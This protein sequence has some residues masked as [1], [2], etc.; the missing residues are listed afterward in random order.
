MLKFWSKT[1]TC[2]I[3]AASALMPLGSSVSS[4]A[5][6]VTA[7]AATTSDF[8]DL[9]QAELTSAMGVGWNVG[10]TCEALNGS[11][12]TETA[13]G[14]PKVTQ[15]LIDEVK[16]EGFKSIRLPVGWLTNIGAA[17]DYTLSSTWLARIKEI[18]DYCVKDDL[19]VIV[20]MHSDGYHSI[21]GAWLFCDAPASEQTAIVDK[22][23]KSW[24]QF[25]DY[26]KDYDEHLIF[27]SMN[28]ELDVIEGTNNQNY[29]APTS[30]YDKA[31]Y[32]NINVYNQAFVDTVRGTGSNN[33]KRWLLIPG[34][35]TSIDYTVDSSYGFV[36]PTDT[37]KRTAISVHFYDPFDFTINADNSK[38]TQ[39]GKD[40]DKTKNSSWGQENYVNTQMSR[41][42]DAFVSKGY[43][44][45]IG[46]F[47]SGDKTYADAQ[48]TKFR[49][50]WSGYVVKMAKQYGCI[51]VY[52]DNGYN[53]KNGLAVIDRKTNTASQPTIIKAMMD[54]MNNDAPIEIS[55]DFVTVPEFA[56]YTGKAVTPAVT[57]KYM[58][59]TLVKGTDYTV[60][61]KNNIKAD[62]ASVTVTGKGKYT[63]TITKNF[64]ISYNIA[65]ATVTGVKNS[66]YTGKPIT[67]SNLVVKYNGE[68]L[69]TIFHYS[70]KY[71]NNTKYGTATITI[72]GKGPYAGTLKKTFKIGN[73]LSANKVSLSTTKYA[74]TGKAKTP[75][76]TVKYGSTKL[77][78]NTDYTVSYKNN[79]KIGTGTVTITGK[80]KYYGTIKKTIKV[81]PK[82][83]KIKSISA[84]T[85][86]FKVSW[87]K[88]TQ[89]TAYQVRYATNSKFT[90]YKYVT[91]SN[92]SLSKTVSK[93]TKGKK[94]YVQVRTYKTVSKTKYY[95]N[96]SATKTVRA[97]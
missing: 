30:D 73:S 81:N 3:A 8:K 69:S 5:G 2:L 79:T 72:S 63:G 75:T 52:W 37:A 35:N 91:V 26:F 74:Y 55:S 84:K 18:V 64:E 47:G 90:S 14:N 12:P 83:Q 27:E 29:G 22:Y 80:G 7:S 21:P 49:A 45:I 50:Y 31:A 25:A 34:W 24:A 70:V 36:A 17:P 54:A 96:W 88:D 82:T 6:T 58:G 33:A 10:N 59:K 78:K 40:A 61:Y 95:G 87:T 23:K 71:S 89:A 32:K 86:G 4:F 51:P 85:K 46:E 94:Y 43:P 15:A 77:K 13:W 68:V 1:L 41:L 60:S 57:V 44:V 97:K 42:Y 56:Y 93:L 66:K 38:I 11:I 53:G 28:E 62:T 16:S 76:V 67:M 65:K 39:W 19:Y 9:T 48:N 20:N 92:K